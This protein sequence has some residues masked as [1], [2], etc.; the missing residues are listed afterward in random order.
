M[1]EHLRSVPEH[2]TVGGYTYARADLVEEA[3]RCR[4]T[5]NAIQRHDA[6]GARRARAHAD[7]VDRALGA[8]A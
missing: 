1:A 5:A 6:D 2:V 7:R 3:R 4:E 8:L